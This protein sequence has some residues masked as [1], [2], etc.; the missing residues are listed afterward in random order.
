[1]VYET[2]TVPPPL[3]SDNFSNS[4][5]L[6]ST[7][8]RYDGSPLRP[9][10]ITDKDRR[11]SD[12]EIDDNA[13]LVISL[14]ILHRED[15]KLHRLIQVATPTGVGQQQT[16]YILVTS[17]YTYILKRGKKLEPFYLLYH[18]TMVCFRWSGRPLLLRSVYQVQQF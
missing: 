8:L 17:D 4:P 11:A 2:L 18:V 5:L 16:C 13:R 12:I 9:R 3:V 15:E 10:E 7:E 14:D 1:M 6:L